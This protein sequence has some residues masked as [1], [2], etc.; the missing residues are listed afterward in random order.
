[1]ARTPCRARR[2]L[3]TK[4]TAVVVAAAALAV[5]LAAAMSYRGVS[6]L[7]G[8]ELERGLE[9]RMHTVHTLVAAGLTPPPQRGGADQVVSGQGAVR[10]LTPSGPR[11]P[12][13]AAALR[14]A[15]TGK[16][17]HREDLVV[18]GT[19]YG[20]LTRPLPGGGAVMVAQSYEGAARVDDAF[21]WRVTG[22][23]AAALA[24]SALLSWFVVGRVLRPVRRLARTTAHI[25]ATRDLTTELPPAGFDEVGQLTRS[26]A[27]M[28]AALRR[29]RDQQQRLVQDASH[30]L[31]TPL[32]SVRGSA[33]LLQRGRGRLTAEDEEQILGTLVTETAALDS[34]MRELVEL[35]TDRYTDEPPAT[36]DL[37]VLAEDT[38]L[39]HRARTGRTIAVTTQAPV[40]VRARPGALQRCVDNL[41]NNA[42]KFS[43]AGTPVTL[44]VEGC[45]LSVRDRGPGIDPADREAVFDRFYRGSRTQS[46]PGSGLGLAI[47]HDSVTADGGTVFAADAEGGGAEVGFVLP[48]AE[49]ASYAP[50]DRRRLRKGPK[51]HAQPVARP[52]QQPDHGP[53]R[54]IL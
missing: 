38:A 4:I 35:A 8:E 54:P 52:A 43:P 6:D 46:T 9:D 45:R 2:T 47:V 51:S 44:H 36:V 19:E 18:D 10:R 13:S 34:L 23:T 33:E 37:A 49:Q 16:G 24:L 12:V 7:V 39:R 14:V 20:V 30:E 50:L 17:G 5:T 41:V 25:T 22:T 48:P 32:T 27:A 1:M 42:V 11:L 29:S 21:L 26:F 31:R 15:R 3:R 28:L 40:P 53:G